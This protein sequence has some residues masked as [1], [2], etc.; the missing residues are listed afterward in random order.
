[1]VHRPN[2]QQGGNGQPPGL[3]PPVGEDQDLFPQLYGGFCLLAE[4]VQGIAQPLLLAQCKGGIQQLVGIT[5]P[6]QVKEFVKVLVA[7]H[8]L[9]EVDL[10]GM[11]RAFVQQVAGLAQAGKERHHQALPKGV[12]GRVAYLGKELF[13]IIG[14][15]LG[16][17]GKY[18]Q[19]RIGP[20]AAYGL[21]AVCRHGSDDHLQVLFGIAKG[22]Q[23]LLQQFSRQGGQGHLRIRHQAQL[24][25]VLA[26][27]LQVGLVPAHQLFDLLIFQHPA[28][29][30]IGQQHFAGLQAPPFEHISGSY[31][32]GAGLRGHDQPPVAGQ[33]VAHR[34]QPVPVQAGAYLPAIGKKEGGRAIPGLHKGRMVFVKGFAAW[35]H[36]AVILPGFGH[37]HHHHMRQRAA[38]KCKQFYQAIQVG[39][40]GKARIRYRQQ[41]GQFLIG[42]E[43]RVH[44]A[45]LAHHFIYIAPNGIDLPIVSNKAKG[46][47]QAPVGKGIGRK[48]G[49]HHGQGRT[50]EGVLQIR[51][52]GLQLI[53]LQLPFVHDSA[54]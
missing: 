32:Q 2:G 24:E 12:N 50:V 6:V 34:P 46:L 19:G 47:R 28:L 17:P 39:R 30:G 49:M 41:P 22:P 44:A 3:H 18:G 4:P 11:F 10:A 48:A 52:V 29:Q 53:G 14:H 13:E 20:H 38:R 54:G 43:G 23:L 5:F 40:V 42:K 31:R 45:L 21:F 51:I 27:P 7:E 15:M 9:R 8:R 1:M 33:A 16:L 35:V 37:Q 26:N 25:A 36:L